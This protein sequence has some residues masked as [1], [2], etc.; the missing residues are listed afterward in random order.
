MRKVSGFQG[1]TLVEMMV[2]VALLSVVAVLAVVS[3]GKYVRRAVVSEAVAMLGEI[4][5]K[6]EAYLA[7]A[8]TYLSTAAGDETAIFPS[9]TPQGHVLKPW[10]THTTDSWAM[11]GINPPR[12][13]LYCGYVAVAGAVNPGPPI[14]F[15]NPV[16]GAGVDI[17]APVPRDA[18][19]NIASAWFY[20]RACCD[21]QAP[22]V[23]GGNCPNPAPDLTVYSVSS[24][25]NQLREQ[26]VGR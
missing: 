24:F 6:Q 12:Q 26:N 1:F 10:G 19:G 5:A 2:V 4:R 11:L 20:A 25:D 21:L 16:G 18:G 15:G 13:Q 22:Y 17:M 14:H 8:G 9:L 3:Y 23:A 7:E